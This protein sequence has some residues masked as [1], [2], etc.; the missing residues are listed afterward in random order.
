MFVQLNPTVLLL[1]TVNMIQMVVVV[2][3]FSFWKEPVYYIQ[4]YR[5]HLH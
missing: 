5:F 1:A 2:A 4:K 3:A